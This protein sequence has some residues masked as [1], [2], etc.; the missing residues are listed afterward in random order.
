MSDGIPNAVAWGEFTPAQRRRAEAL[1]LARL[2]FP[3]NS[4]GMSQYAIAS[5][6]IYG[7]RKA[8]ES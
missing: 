5:W 1:L 3:G 8:A 6:V 2:L 7:R 4:L